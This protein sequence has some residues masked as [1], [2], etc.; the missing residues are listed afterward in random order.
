MKPLFQICIN[1]QATKFAFADKL[2]LIDKMIELQRS[3]VNGSI[4]FIIV[5]L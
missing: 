5:D 4:T 2:L 3:F 1:N